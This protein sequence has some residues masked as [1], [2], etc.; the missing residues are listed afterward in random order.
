MPEKNYVIV[1]IGTGNSRVA[2]VSQDGTIRDLISFEN[3][4]YKDL[5]YDDARY[6]N[7]AE[8]KAHILGACKTLLKKHDNLT[9]A[10]VSSSGARESIVCYDENANAFLGLP[11]IDNRGRKWMD[12]NTR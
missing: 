8:W 9:I 6:F 11:N 10:A 3:K 5:L 2:L 7:P 12:E 1:D 4:Y